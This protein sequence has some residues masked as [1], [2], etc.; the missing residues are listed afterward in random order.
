VSTSPSG[1]GARPTLEFRHVDVFSDRPFGGNGLI[2][3]FDDPDDKLAGDM[4]S[5]AREMRQFE[6]IVVGVPSTDGRVAARIFTADEELP[7]A[8]HPVLGAAAALHERLWPEDAARSWAFV[9]AGREIAV[10]SR[11]EADY[12]HASMNQG[13]VTIEPG[14]DRSRS[15]ELAAAVG[16]A[17]D[18]LHPDLPMQVASTGLPYLIIPVVQGLGRAR[19][20]VGDLERRLVG[21]GAK[22]VYLLDPEGREGRTWDNAGSVEDIATGSAAGPVFGYLRHHGLVSGRDTVLLRQGRYV[23][24]PCEIAITPASDGD[25][26]VGGSVAPVARGVLDRLPGRS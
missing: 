24:R 25:L 11:R 4:V 21:V 22:F 1:A 2:A 8:G 19:V 16:L 20:A 7:F 18:D 3:V 12:F 6:I 17:R 5:L 26:W 10:Q 9:V 13:P 23:G 15:A 14:L